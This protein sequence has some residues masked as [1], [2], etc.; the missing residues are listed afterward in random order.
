VSAERGIFAARLMAALEAAV[1]GS[2]TELR[3]SLAQD[4]GDAYS[5]V[6]LRWTVPAAGFGEA[7][8]TAPF[9]LAN[10]GGELPL[11]RSDPDQARAGHRLLALRFPA[12]PLFWRVDLE[13]VA[14]DGEGAPSDAPPPDWPAA[15]SALENAIAAVKAMARGDADEARRL[16][17][18]GHARLGDDPAA[19]TTPRALALRAAR[20]DP[21][22]APLAD[23]VPDAGPGVA[24]G[25]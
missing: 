15:A 3:G 8:G 7:V 20:E 16:L 12:L 5:D 4:A 6:D 11:T 17:E 25:A 2:R 21:A 24:P 10:V 9:A 18:H 14:D 19:A 13:V 1:P 23:R 22:L